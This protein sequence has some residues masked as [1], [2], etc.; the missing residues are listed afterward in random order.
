[1]KNNSNRGQM[2]MSVGTIVT[3][4]LLVTLLVLGIVLIKNIFT[5]A[6]G[7]VGL[8][9]QKI[10]SEITKLFASEDQETAILPANRL[11][12]IKQGGSDEVTLGIKN[13]GST[14]DAYN[15]IIKAEPGTNCP[16]SLT[17]EKILDWIVL[18]GASNEI[19]VPSGSS[20]YKRISITVPVESPLCKVRYTLSIS[21]ES[22]KKF[23]EDFDIEVKAK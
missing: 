1:M 17:S 4:V 19:A 18:G 10:K 11:V 15:Y 8:T 23:T 5:S 6:T 3:I 9:D 13:L 22:G 12:Q 2:E 14:G 16:N 7:T 21:S 20:A